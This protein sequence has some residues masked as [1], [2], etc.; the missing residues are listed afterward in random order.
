MERL[1]Q[2]NNKKP[3]TCC[4]LT[5]MVGV[6]QGPGFIGVEMCITP[7]PRPREVCVS[8]EASF[9]VKRRAVTV[10]TRCEDNGDVY[11]TLT[12]LQRA[13]GDSLEVQR[14]DALPHIKCPPDG[15][16]SLPC[17]HFRGHILYTGGKTGNIGEAMAGICPFIPLFK[18][19]TKE[20]SRIQIDSR[21]GSN[22]VLIEHP[23]TLETTNHLLFGWES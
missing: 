22:G 14:R 7:Y 20:I 23:L 15:F 6:A 19:S 13:V 18:P 1:A 3:L 16:V 11:I 5:I 21:D 9:S 8:Q 2:T 10:E 17:T 12:A 4:S